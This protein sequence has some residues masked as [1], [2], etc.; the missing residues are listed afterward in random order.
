LIVL[1]A[2][3][4]VVWLVLSVE[5]RDPGLSARVYDQRMYPASRIKFAMRYCDTVS[6]EDGGHVVMDLRR[7][8]LIE[9]D[10][11]AAATS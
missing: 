1:S 11:P 9:P 3:V 4:G 6:E 8:S 2:M 7:I 5:A 10:H